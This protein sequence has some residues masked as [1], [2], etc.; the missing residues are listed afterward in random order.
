MPTITCKHC[1]RTKEVKPYQVL[2]TGNYCS[3]RCRGL[4]GTTKVSVSCR[5]CGR[6]IDVF[7]RRL[8]AGGNCCSRECTANLRR[9]AATLPCLWC[10]R[11]IEVRQYLLK[12]GGKEGRYCGEECRIAAMRE[13]RVCPCPNCGKEV[14]THP[15]EQS[16][17]GNHCSA[18]C[19]FA[20][21]RAAIRRYSLTTGLG[22]DLNLA[23]ASVVHAL[24]SLGVPAPVSTIAEV[25][26]RTAKTIQHVVY[27][28]KR[29][30]VVFP[31]APRE[32]QGKATP[33]VYWSLTLQSINSYG[34]CH[35]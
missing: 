16:E 29:K 33:R 34:A 2:E 21:L 1:G 7:P 13:S 35:E 32:C 17:C 3:N 11:E 27:R 8:L 5:V 30:G 6:L 22:A 23:E 12:R 31:Y 9:T 15:C 19:R 10:S 25:S 28:L 14:Y 24:A 4:A 20:R 18:A 26:G